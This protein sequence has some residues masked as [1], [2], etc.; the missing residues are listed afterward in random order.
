M[1][2]VVVVCQLFGIRCS[3]FVVCYSLFGLFSRFGAVRCVVFVVSCLLCV[4]VRCS[5]FV[6]WCF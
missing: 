5:L 4:V 1:F 6:V 2:V 3:S